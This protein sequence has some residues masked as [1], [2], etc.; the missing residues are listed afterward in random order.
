MTPW[1]PD[2]ECPYYQCRAVIQPGDDPEEWADDHHP[3]GRFGPS[4]REYETG[5]EERDGE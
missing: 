2:E 3:L 5:I 4:E 1:G